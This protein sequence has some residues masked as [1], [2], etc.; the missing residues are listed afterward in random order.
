[1]TLHV[2]GFDLSLTSTGHARIGQDGQVR[3]LVRQT[4]TV[5]GDHATADR[6]WSIARWC[7]RQLTEDTAL[8]VLEAPSFGSEYGQPHERSGL[9]W[10]VRR[11]LAVRQ[12]PDGTP[13]PVGRVVPAT[14][15]ARVAGHGRASKADMRKAVA[16]LYPGQ[17]LHRITYDEA[18]AVALAHLGVIRLRWDGHPYV[19]AHAPDSAGVFEHLPEHAPAAASPSIADPFRAVP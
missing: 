16:K 15:K 5:E 9:W 2:A 17:G 11:G 14:L 7:M 12:R 1:M 13:L 18:D 3:T 4:D 8:V 19:G 10:A 6:I